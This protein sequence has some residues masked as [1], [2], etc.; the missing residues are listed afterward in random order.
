MNSVM[1]RQWDASWTVVGLNPGAA[2]RIV[3][4]AIPVNFP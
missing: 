2:E 4:S 1:F 3:L